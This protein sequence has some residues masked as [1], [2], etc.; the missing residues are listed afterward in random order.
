VILMKNEYSAVYF[1]A[2]RFFALERRLR[3]AFPVASLSN[4][5]WLDF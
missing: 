4:M 3:A 1:C 5:F 2:F